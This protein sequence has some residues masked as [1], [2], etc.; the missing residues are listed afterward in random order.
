[1][2][3][4]NQVQCDSKLVMVDMF[5]MDNIS[6]QVFVKNERKSVKQYCYDTELPFKEALNNI[7]GD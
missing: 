2:K 3:Y 5:E 6:V 4:L 7:L 1:M